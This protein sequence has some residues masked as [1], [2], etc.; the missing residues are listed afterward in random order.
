MEIIGIAAGCCTTGAFLPQ[1]LRTW[2]TR[3]VE[4]ISLRMYMLLC[5]GV[6]LWLI[7]GV[8]VDSL[9]V[10]L[11][12]SVTLILAGAVLVMKVL[13]GRVTADSDSDPS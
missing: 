10:V 1:V 9:S 13:Y 11:A 12:N 4:D 5:V 8:L 6:I 3:S 7:Y 2:K